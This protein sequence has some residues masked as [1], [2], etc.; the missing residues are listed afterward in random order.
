MRY[1]CIFHFKNAVLTNEEY[2]YMFINLWIFS[3]VIITNSVNWFLPGFY[4][5]TYE[6]CTCAAQDYNQES[7]FERTALVSILLT[8]TI[9]VIVSVKI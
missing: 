2:W 1:T 9:Y 6:M 4:S 7:K 5:L 8:M 3:A